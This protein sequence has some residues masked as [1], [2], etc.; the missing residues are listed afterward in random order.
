MLTSSSANFCTNYT[1]AHSAG[2][3]GL[4]GVVLRDKVTNAVVSPAPA[5]L[6]LITP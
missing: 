6:G 2:S 4:D 1:A 3:G 5:K